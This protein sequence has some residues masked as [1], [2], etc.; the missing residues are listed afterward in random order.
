LW[1]WF[2]KL[3]ILHS[4]CYVR[5]KLLSDPTFECSQSATPS[6]VALVYV[7]ATQLP[8]GVDTLIVVYDFSN[9]FIT[10]CHI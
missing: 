10:N 4:G 2:N 8:G 5:L 3:S 6:S 1:S 9:V 7:Y